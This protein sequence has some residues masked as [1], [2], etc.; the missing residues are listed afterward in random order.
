[1]MEGTFLFTNADRTPPWKAPS[2]YKPKD[3]DG[4][5]MKYP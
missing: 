4:M 3:E 5:R 1:M 2:D